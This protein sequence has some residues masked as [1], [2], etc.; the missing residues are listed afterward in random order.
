MSKDD[1]MS[2]KDFMIGAFVGGIVGA[3]AALLYAPK[4]GK[5]I[6]QDLGEQTI[7]IKEKGSHL[8]QK[9][10]NTS[11]SIAR[12]VGDQSTNVVNRV[13]DWK[14]ISNANPTEEDTIEAET[15]REL[16]SSSE[17]AAAEEAPS[18]PEKE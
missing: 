5:E 18:E 7:T 11:T 14:V 1:S 17:P 16:N 13:K 12:T 3:G 9:A 2:L 15:L 4:S 10:K 6:R 8:A